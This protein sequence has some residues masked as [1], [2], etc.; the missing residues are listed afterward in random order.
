LEDN[1][2]EDKIMVVVSLIL[3]KEKNSFVCEVKSSEEVPLEVAHNILI[4][5]IDNISK[6]YMGKEY[7]KEKA[8]ASVVEAYRE[9][10]EGIEI[11]DVEA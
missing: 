3:E 5:G 11:S 8:I 4:V 6:E 1:S 9:L 10:P 7:T 2:I